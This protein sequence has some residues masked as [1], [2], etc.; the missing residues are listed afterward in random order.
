MVF[1]L[2]FSKQIKMLNKILNQRTTD[3]KTLY[4][5]AACGLLT[6]KSDGSIVNG[7][8]TLLSWLNLIEYSNN[9]NFLDFLN[10]ESR[11]YFNLF[12]LPMLKLHGEVKEISMILETTSGQLPILLNAVFF[13]SA[14]H[15]RYISASLLKIGDNKK[16][17]SDRLIAYSQAHLVRA[18]LANILSLIDILE[19]EKEGTDACTLKMLKE[20]ASK[21]DQ[22]VK[23]IVNQCTY[24]N[25]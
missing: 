1:N 6:F 24:R 12:V 19:S 18:P 21:L 14:D 8:K 10:K 7:N 4:Q 13:D 2:R 16:F 22:I 20:S 9:T 23:S 15:G 3:Y 5:H 17:E 25:D 11:L